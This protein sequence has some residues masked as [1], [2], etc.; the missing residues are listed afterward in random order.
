MQFN[1][2]LG[3]QLSEMRTNR[4]RSLEWLGT[5]TGIDVMTLCFYEGGLME[6]T[7]DHLCSICD[8]FDVCPAALI[9]Q[10]LPHCYMPKFD[11]FTPINEAPTRSFAA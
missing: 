11:W 4:E 9:D 1:I 8:A 2:D 10:V 6:I 7:I 5:T 3:L